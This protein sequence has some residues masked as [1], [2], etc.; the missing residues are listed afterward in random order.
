MSE[1]IEAVVLMLVFA[2]LTVVIFNT[3]KPAFD[4]GKAGIFVM[5]VCVSALAVIGMCR[6]LKGVTS[7]ILS[8]YAAL[9]ITI[10]L[11]LMIWLFRKYFDK[12]SE[13]FEKSKP[14]QSSEDEL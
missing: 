8:P 1:N 2:I 9:G 5:A 13:S 7:I 12:N 6:F 4:F 11:V 14:R 10:L 3:L